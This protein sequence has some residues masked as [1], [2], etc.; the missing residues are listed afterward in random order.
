MIFFLKIF[1]HWYVYYDCMVN[2]VYRNLSAN[3]VHFKKKN[4]YNTIQNHSFTKP[5]PVSLTPV[6]WREENHYGVSDKKDDHNKNATK[7]FE[8]PP[9]EQRCNTHKDNTKTKEK[10]Y[11][12]AVHDAW[13]IIFTH[14]F[15]FNIF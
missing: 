15:T 4:M 3:F 8:N 7:Q 13:C 14:T 5:N 11:K 2:Y 10:L 1:R 6:I 9:P 12:P